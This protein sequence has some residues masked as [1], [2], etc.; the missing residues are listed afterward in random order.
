MGPHEA[1]LFITSVIARV[2]ILSITRANLPF[3]AVMLAVL[4]LVIL[5][6]DAIVLSVPRMFGF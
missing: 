1:A 6:P 4:A 3:I 2:D 5:F